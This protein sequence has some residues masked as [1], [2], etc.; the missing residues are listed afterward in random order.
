MHKKVKAKA[1]NALPHHEQRPTVIPTEDRNLQWGISPAKPGQDG[2]KHM[3]G[4]AP[5]K[6]LTCR[7]GDP[8]KIFY[9]QIIDLLSN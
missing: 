3:P 9:V 5:L 2:V 6:H 1:R 4:G 7:A 8:R